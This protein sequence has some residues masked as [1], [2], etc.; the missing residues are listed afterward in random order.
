MGDLVNLHDSLIHRLRAA[1]KAARML[2]ND[3]MLRAEK[4][5][6]AF[7]EQKLLIIPFLS[8]YYANGIGYSVIQTR[9]HHNSMLLGVKGKY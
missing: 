3:I 8:L 4:S 9:G 6:E 2:V 1:V 5:A 7:Q